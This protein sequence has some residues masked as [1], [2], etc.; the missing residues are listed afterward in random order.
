MNI[1]WQ[2]R[3]LFDES[4]VAHPSGQ[5]LQVRDFGDK[6]MPVGHGK[7]VATHE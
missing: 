3:Q 4:Q 2:V 5:F 1:S 7:E 6:S